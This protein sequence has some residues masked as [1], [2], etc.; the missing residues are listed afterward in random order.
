MYLRYIIIFIAKEIV[1][2]GPYFEA[3]ILILNL[4]VYGKF[5]LL[6][7]CVMEYRYLL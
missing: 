1:E 4:R 3:H 5:K 6:I 2:K 7:F